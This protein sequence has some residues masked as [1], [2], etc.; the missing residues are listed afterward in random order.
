[1]EI[2]V[3]LVE[4]ADG[5][6]DV[7]DARVVATFLE[8]IDATF[9]ICDATEERMAASRMNGTRPWDIT[10]SVAFSEI[11]GNPDELM[12]MIN[13]DGPEGPGFWGQC[14]VTRTRFTVDAGGLVSS[15]R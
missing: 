1:M 12:V 5:G 10:C 8:S 6:G 13:D 15:V 7:G 11:E 4:R 2:S 14:L 9:D 3:Y